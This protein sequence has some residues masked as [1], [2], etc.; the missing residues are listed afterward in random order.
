MTTAA[1]LQA[2]QQA[3]AMNLTTPQIAAQTGLSRSTVKRYR[4]ALGL[5]ANDP[6][7]QLARYGVAVVTALASGRGLTVTPA[8]PGGAHDLVVAGRRV[9]VRAARP[10]THRIKRG[11]YRRWQF[12]L[13]SS[14]RS[15]MPVY[16]YNADKGRDAEV[17]VFV[18]APDVPFV[19][20]VYLF[21][22]AD[23]SKTLTFGWCDAHADHRD[24]WLLFH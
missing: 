1:Q 9:D 4:A 7:Q 23:V 2:V 16:D 6:V 17:V 21:E 3:H 5:G 13:K 18:C 22:A 24:A 19:P 20:V 15:V 12:W 10:V 14:R 11:E 8:P